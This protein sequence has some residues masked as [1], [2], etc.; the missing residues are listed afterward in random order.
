MAHQQNHRDLETL[1]PV[2]VRHRAFGLLLAGAS[3]A[4]SAVP[5]S[6]S[7]Q[8]CDPAYTSHCVPTVSEVGDLNCDY[9]Y[10]QGIS[11]IVLADPAIDPHGLDGWNS[12]DDGYGCEGS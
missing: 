5:S 8:S 9:F 11:G 7:A 4:A 12:V 1:M 3:L 6:I 2:P 10:A